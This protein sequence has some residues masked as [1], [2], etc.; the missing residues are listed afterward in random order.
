MTPEERAKSLSWNPATTLRSDLDAIVA[1]AIR[2][3]VVE[4]R[5]ACAKK[6]D[7]IYQQHGEAVRKSVTNEVH[8]IEKNRAYGAGEC[9]GEIRQRR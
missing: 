8:L 6:C 3:A 2:E 5:E 1:Q 7:A 9:A 4:E